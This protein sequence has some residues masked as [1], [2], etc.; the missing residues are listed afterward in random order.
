MRVFIS[1]DMEGATGVCHR[2][3]LLAGGQDYER[4]RRWLTG[5]INAAVE[6]ALSGGASEVVVA[7]GHATMRNIL[8]DELHEKAQLLCGPANIRNRPLGQLAALEPNRFERA[9]LIGYHT[10]AG[11]PGGLLAHTWVGSLIHEIRLNGAP[12]GE[13]LLNAAL[14]GEFGI[15]V[16]FATGADDFVREVKADLGADLATTTVKK[17]LGPS[18]VLTLSP[19]ESAW[20]IRDGA[21]RAMRSSRPPLRID[22]AV[23]VAIDFH[24]RADCEQAAETGGERTGDRTLRFGGDSVAATI[25][26]V[27]RAITNALRSEGPF[28]Q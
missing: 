4:A 8:L 5:D 20:Q 9:M 24:R 27:W 3:H 14:L 12:A 19:S 2:D 26:A 28:L 1:A 18:A 25:E 13:A 6:G 22:G 7:D 16:V 21:E 10:R 15:P 23:D 11:T 17:T